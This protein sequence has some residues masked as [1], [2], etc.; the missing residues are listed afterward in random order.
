MVICRLVTHKR[1]LQGKK[2]VKFSLRFFAI[3]DGCNLSVD[4]LKY[5]GTQFSFGGG[6]A[7]CG[8]RRQHE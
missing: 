3:P 5:G 7:Q 6:E 2:K 4:R 8:L 1:D